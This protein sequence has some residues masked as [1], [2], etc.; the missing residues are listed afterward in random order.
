MDTPLAGKPEI[1]AVSKAELTG[2][3]EVR[4]AWSANSASRCW[5]F[6]R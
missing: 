1:V 5:R 2:S 4:D 3:G 6:R